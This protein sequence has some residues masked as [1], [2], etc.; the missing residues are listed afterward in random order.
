MALSVSG[1]DALLADAAGRGA[2]AAA[3]A[4]EHSGRG[5]A[6]GRRTR[7]IRR[8]RGVVGGG[9]RVVGGERPALSAGGGGHSDSWCFG[10]D[11]TLAVP[12][13]SRGL[14]VPRR[15]RGQAPEQRWEQRDHLELAQ[16]PRDL[17]PHIASGARRRRGEVGVAA[18]SA[19]SA[20][21][22]DRS[23]MTCWMRRGR[24]CCRLPGLGEA[25]SLVVGGTGGEWGGCRA[26][27]VGF[28]WGSRWRGGCVSVCLSS[29]ETV[30]PD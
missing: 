23:Y 19:G 7:G 13:R 17:P 29:R 2:H 1:A 27:G 18:T 15:S 16:V 26:L 8:R 14:A 10:G 9:E 20:I 11:Y 21:A 12:R 24:P 25:A 3:K 4:L 5:R 6:R 30:S 22:V 28:R